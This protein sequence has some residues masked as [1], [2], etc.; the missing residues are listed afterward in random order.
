MMKRAVAWVAF[1][2]AAVSCGDGG[3]PAGEKLGDVS[4]AVTDE[5]GDHGAD[6][7]WVRCPHRVKE[8]VA[9]PLGPVI[10]HGFSEAPGYEAGLFDDAQL[11]VCAP[12]QP[13]H[14]R[15]RRP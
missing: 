2:A 3:P 5:P 15:R 10:S 14:P 1:A 12:G 7:P 8:G 11:G 6:Q 4:A 9:D 13:A